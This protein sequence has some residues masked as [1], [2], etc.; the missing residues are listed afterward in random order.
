MLVYP[1]YDRLKIRCRHGVNRRLMPC[2][3][4]R[5]HCQN[6]TVQRRYM[7]GTEIFYYVFGTSLCILTQVFR[8]ERR[9]ARNK[10]VCLQS[11][12]TAFQKLLSP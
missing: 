8:D 11:S 1:F 7:L 4:R 2:P 9:T 5:K 3:C 10:Y 6:I 12:T